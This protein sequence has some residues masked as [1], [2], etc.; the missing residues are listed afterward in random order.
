M[1][2][3]RHGGLLLLA[4]FSELALAALVLAAPVPMW[5]ALP[6]VYV[7][8]VTG[9]AGL[10]T[11][12]GWTGMLGKG[13]D[14]RLPWWSVVFL[15]W[16]VL[17]RGVA[18]LTATRPTFSQVTET[19]WVGGWPRSG[20]HTTWPAVIDV[21]CE[22]PRQSPE[23]DYLCLPVWDRSAPSLEQ[24]EAAVVFHR[25]HAAAGRPVLVHCAQGRGRSVTVA[26]AILVA[27]GRSLADAIALIS[28]RRPVAHLIRLQRGVLEAWSRK[29]GEIS[30]ASA[31]SSS[32]AS[33]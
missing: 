30:A 22:L 3:P 28:K 19:L 26:A 8:L 21:T 29:N 15:S 24:L 10:A 4:A 6:F 9:A 11:W 1:K 32:L 2:A 14:G 16:H 13:A 18:R 33:Q 5:I 7:G 23:E 25:R 20:E 27:E 31:G 17:V 12:Q